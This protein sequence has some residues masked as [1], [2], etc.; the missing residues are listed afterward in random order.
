ME[1]ARLAATA[2]SLAYDPSW[3]PI[4][5]GVS[6]VLQRTDARALHWVLWWVHAAIS[7]GWVAAIPFGKKTMHLLLVPLNLLFEDDRPKGRLDRLDVEAAFE[8][9]EVLGT[10]TLADLSRRQLLEVK[11]CTECGRCDLSCP[12]FLTGKPLSP[13]GIVT[14][15][16]DQAQREQRWLGAR[17]EPQP[18]VGAAVQLEAL[19]ACTSCMACTEVCPV[20]IDPLAHVQGLRRGEV[21]MNDAYPDTFTGVFAGTEKRGNPWEQHPSSRMDWA[22]GLEVETMAAVAQSGRSVE[23]LFWVGCAA[24]F[25]PRSQ[26]IARSV[27]KILRAAGISFAVLGEEESCTG[28]PARRIGHEYLFQ[29]QAEQNVATLTGYSFEK[30]L[31]LCPHCLN[32]LR[33]EYPDYGPLWQVVHHTELI[34]S[35]LGEGRI[36][37]ERPLSGVA[38]YHDSCYLGPRNGVFDA[39]RRILERVPGLRTVEMVRSREAGMCC[40]AGGGMMWTEEK[41]GQEVNRLRV[42][43]AERVLGSG[44]RA[45][46]ASSC[47][48]CTI[49]LEDGIAARHGS[50]V[51]E[52]DIAELV[53]EAMG[54]DD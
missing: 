38:A 4:G 45:T 7:L 53:A 26:K 20:A 12:A 23:Y 39:L 35:L 13:R 22:A 8:N 44:E 40:G 47:P 46:V 48:F 16:R 14:G 25:D 19:W 36:A 9:D 42:A 33:N 24:S 17:K 32:T 5:H 3:S 49:M 30:V 15:A 29:M 51:E 2:S 21:M 27:V 10:Q 6:A 11:A 54:L 41:Q 28:D 31:T 18:L 50:E 37:L 1:G 43:E 34:D 52:K